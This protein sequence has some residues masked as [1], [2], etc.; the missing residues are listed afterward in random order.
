MK[1]KFEVKDLFK[2]PNILCYIRIALV[3]LFVYLYFTAEEP[4]DY[5]VATLVVM[6]SGITDFLD[7]Q[8]A[9]RCNM[10]TD[11]GKIIDPAADKLMQLAMLVALT[12]RVKY[13]Y[14][15][16]INIPYMCILA[17]YL[18]VKEVVMAL[19]G[20]VVMKRANRRLDGAKWYGKVCTAVLYVCMLALVAFP[21]MPVNLQYVIMIVCA[22][23]LTFAF[24]MY[25]RIYIIML[26]DNHYGNDERKLY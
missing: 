6:L 22:A 7:G 14:L 26:K 21:H 23:V 5:Y 9:R 13:M 24:I 10:I 17:V 2:L 19:M 11:L 1:F 20:L 12:V 15:L 3:P 18:I 8:I 16:V 25:I 4:V